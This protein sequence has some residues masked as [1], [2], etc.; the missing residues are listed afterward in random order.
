M[1]KKGLD[2]DI[3]FKFEEEE[4]KFVENPILIMK[5]KIIKIIIK[6]N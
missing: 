4:Y 6:K 3:K 5:E 2:K 1:I